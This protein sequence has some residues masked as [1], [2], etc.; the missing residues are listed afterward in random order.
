LNKIIE[1]IIKRLFISK[2]RREA[3]IRE[4]KENPNFRTLEEI[5]KTG[6]HSEPTHDFKLKKGEI[7]TIYSPDLGNQKGLILYKWNFRIGDIVKY[8][9]VLCEVGNKKITMEFESMFEGKIIWCCH[10]NKLVPSG[11]EI[12]KIEGI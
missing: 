6:C 3:L 5:E 12:C 9:D 4:L 2:K 8:G 1:A 10:E 7:Q 11:T